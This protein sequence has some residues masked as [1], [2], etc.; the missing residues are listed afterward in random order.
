MGRIESTFKRA[1]LKSYYLQ[2]AILSAFLLIVQLAFPKTITICKSCEIITLKEAIASARPYDTI[3]VKK[4]TYKEY[5]INIDKP[6]TIIGE[7][8]PVIDG[9]DKGE[10]IRI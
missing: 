6:L 5:N 4:G 3:I 10:I 1:T 7:G 2:I 9:E 8:Y